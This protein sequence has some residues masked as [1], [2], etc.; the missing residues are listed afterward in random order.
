MEKGKDGDREAQREAERAE[1]QRDK[2]HVCGSCLCSLILAANQGLL[3]P[4]ISSVSP[5]CVCGHVLQT[6]VVS[7]YF[8]AQ[9]A[10]DSASRRLGC[11]LP[12]CPA[13]CRLPS[14]SS[15]SGTVRCPTPPPFPC[16]PEPAVSWGV[17][18]VTAARLHLLAVIAPG[19][20]SGRFK[21]R[22]TPCIIC[23]HIYI[24]CICVLCF[25]NCEFAPFPSSPTRPVLLFSLFSRGESHS[26]G[27]EP[28]FRCFVVLP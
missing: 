6:V 2:L 7:L 19:P 20:L 23:A 14:R 10:P 25:E 1:R 11:W 8:S 12:C 3:P 18:H 28:G 9:S 27:E 13:V 4:Q 15:I 21:A 5:V 17:L 26:D 22:T 24:W 16:K